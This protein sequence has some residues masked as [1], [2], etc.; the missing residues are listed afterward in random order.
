[1]QIRTATISDLAVVTRCADR[2]FGVYPRRPGNWVELALQIRA[3]SVHVICDAARVLGYISFSANR[4]HLFVETI[5]VLPRRHGQGLGSRLLAF[6]E[7]EALR[8][9]LRS[10]RL[11]T[12][13]K[14]ADNLTFYRH[15]GYHETDR[16]DEGRFSRV[17]Y[18]KDIA[19]R[20][21]HH[22][23]AHSNL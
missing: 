14:I 7:K 4:D 15:R 3:R 8:L 12:D 6:A 19:S 20:W 21:R 13:G 17:F 23:T 10:V 5:A 2:A 11:F 1:M 18:S 16:C 9:G 22:R